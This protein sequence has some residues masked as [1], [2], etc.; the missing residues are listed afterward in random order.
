MHD[1]EISQ[2]TRETLCHL[3]YVYKAIMSSSSSEIGHMELNEMD[4]ET[5]TTSPQVAPIPYI[6]PLK[7][8]KWIQKELEGLAKMELSNEAFAIML[9]Q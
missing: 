9:P 5:Y 8:H 1:A 2:H 4:I 6:L 3:L 7:H